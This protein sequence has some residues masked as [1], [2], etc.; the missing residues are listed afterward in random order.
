MSDLPLSA[1]G[2]QGILANSQNAFGNSAGIPDVG[3]TR[4]A[5][6]NTASNTTPVNQDANDFTKDWPTTQSYQNSVIAALT[7]GRG[8]VPNYGVQQ[9]APQQA[10]GKYQ[11]VDLAPRPDLNMDPATQQSVQDLFKTRE[12]LI[13][14][15]Q[16]ARLQAAQM[17]APHQQGLTLASAIPALLLSAFAKHPDV[18][19]NFLGSYG[20]AQNQQYQN[21][22]ADYQQQQNVGNVGAQNSEELAGLKGQQAQAALAQ[23]QARREMLLKAYQAEL[24]YGG[25]LNVASVNAN[26]AV[27]VAQ[28]NADARA[29][30]A[31]LKNLGVE[32]ANDIKLLLAGSPAD[33]Q[34][35]ANR[36]YA[37]RPESFTNPDGSP[38]SPDQIAQVA[39]QLTPSQQK[40]MANIDRANSLAKL[41]SSKALT[42]DE[43]RDAKRQNILEKT[44]EAVTKSGLNEAM[45]AKV[46]A[47]AAIIPEQF[48]VAYANKAADTALKTQRIFEIQQRMQGGGPAA[49]GAQLRASSAVQRGLSDQSNIISQSMN[50]IKAKYGGKAPPADGSNNDYLEYTKLQNKQSDLQDQMADMTEFVDKI[51]QAQASKVIPNTPATSGGA[52]AFGVPQPKSKTVDS[53]PFASTIGGLMGNIGNGANAV[54]NPAANKAAAIQQEK[55]L[56]NAAIRSGAPGAQVMQ[57]LAQR[58]QA[59]TAGR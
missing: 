10:R 12:D 29:A 16:A 5:A 14:Q 4:D 39:S 13:R 59:I 48:K 18:V 30:A 38:M 8:A 28:M 55:A 9:Q 54:P 36:M 35:A 47:E 52:N 41:Y 50:S 25:K 7:G 37:R 51:R 57:R 26:R 23:D 32:D 3:S 24:G 56:A 44:H 22:L 31:K 49:I 53:A 1:F 19:N 2:L 46:A 40:D 43:L 6:L 20:Q 42:E 33:K 11:P 45:Q 27:D 34:L 58:I 17:A 21:K 15:A